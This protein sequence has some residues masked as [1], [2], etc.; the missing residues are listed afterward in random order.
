MRAHQKGK[1]QWT[2]VLAQKTSILYKEKVSQEHLGTEKGCPKR[3]APN[4]RHLT[5]R[6]TLLGARSWTTKPL[7]ILS[8]LF[9]VQ[10]RAD[11]P[12]SLE[13]EEIVLASPSQ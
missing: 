7:G 4:Q 3:Q 1:S 9:S 2:E 13:E 10:K 12:P 5:S 6:L 11:I 8:N